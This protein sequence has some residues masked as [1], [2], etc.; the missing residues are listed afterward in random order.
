MQVKSSSFLSENFVLAE[1][2]KRPQHHSRVAEGK[3]KD[4]G[5]ATKGEAGVG[6]RACSGG[7]YCGNERRKNWRREC[8]ENNERERITGVVC[9]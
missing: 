4:E 5:R 3:P 2:V 9:F 7:C 8:D 6:K 1:E